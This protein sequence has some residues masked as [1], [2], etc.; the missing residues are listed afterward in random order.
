MSGTGGRPGSRSAGRRVQAYLAS[1]A[2]TLHPRLG[3]PEL[4]LQAYTHMPKLINEFLNLVDPRNV[5]YR[6][7]PNNQALHGQDHTAEY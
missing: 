3:R 7:Y 5:L 4:P 1:E 2:A 6:E